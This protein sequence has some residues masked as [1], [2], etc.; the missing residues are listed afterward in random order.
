MHIA[1][2]RG[3]AGKQVLEDG[4]ELESNSTCTPMISRR[5]LSSAVLSFSATAIAQ[6]PF[7]WPRVP[8]AP[9]L[10]RGRGRFGLNAHRTY[11]RSPTVGA[12]LA[13]SSACAISR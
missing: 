11:L 8:A 13:L 7:I 10:Q 3:D 1:A 2:G 5:D 4:L 12:G 6:E 9:Q